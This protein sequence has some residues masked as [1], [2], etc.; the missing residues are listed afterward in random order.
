MRAPRSNADDVADSR[1]RPL[2]SGAATSTVLDL[3]PLGARSW[4]LPSAAVVASVDGTPSMV[5]CTLAPSIAAPAGSRTSPV[6]GVPASATTNGLP[7][8]QLLI[9]RG[10][11][12]P[13]DGTT[14]TV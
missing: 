2:D 8:D 12:P 10:A 1:G 7:G 14:S 13:T 11:A 3:V 6:T 4:K 9:R 5:S